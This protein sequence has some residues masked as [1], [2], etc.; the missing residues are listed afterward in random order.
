MRSN[1]VPNNH[2]RRYGL[3]SLLLTVS[4]VSLIA[5]WFGNEV[6]CSRRKAIIVERIERS[7][8]FVAYDWE[9]TA[10]GRIRDEN[11]CIVS[12]YKEPSCPACLRR[13]FGDNLFCEPV[14]AAFD[15]QDAATQEC[16]VQFL[17]ELPNLK[18]VSIEWGRI[19]NSSLRRFR[20]SETYGR[21]RC[22]VRDLL[23]MTSI[24]SRS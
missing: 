14:L 12:W 6:R 9:T 17:S 23:T 18:Y 7:G 20:T 10:K 13:W 19:S 15:L 8:G 21:F 22:T 4:C 5:A 24:T 2:R 3:R 16:G 1:S 11:G